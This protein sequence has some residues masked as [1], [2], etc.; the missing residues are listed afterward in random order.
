[1]AAQQLISRADTEL[2]CTNNID[3]GQNNLKGE[4]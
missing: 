2:K 3:F 4:T 1:M